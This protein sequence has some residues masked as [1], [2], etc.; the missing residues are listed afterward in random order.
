MKPYR[1]LSGNS[2]VLA[3]AS[4]ADWILVRFRS[5]APYRYSHAIAGVRHVEAMKRLAEAGRGLSGY[6][7]VHQPRPDPRD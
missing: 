6:I 5:G 3:Y 7:A 4:G 1:N 2:G